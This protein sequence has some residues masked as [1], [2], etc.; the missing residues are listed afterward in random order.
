MEYGSDYF[1]PIIFKSGNTEAQA[2]G[3]AVAEWLLCHGYAAHVMESG[4]PLSELGNIFCVFVLGGDGTIIGVARQL[5]GKGI[6]IFGINFGRVG[7]LSSA[8]PGNWQDVF[9]S[10]LSHGTLE[11]LAL[12]WKLIKNSG[13]A[14]SGVAVNELVLSRGAIARLVNIRVG[15]NYQSLG[16]LRCD[17][18]IICTP[19]GSTGYSVSAGG[20][21]MSAQME[22]I[23]L[24]PICPYLTR[25]S[26]M[27]FPGSTNFS[28]KIFPGSTDCYMTVDGQEGQK[29][30]VEDVLEVTGLPG[31][32]RF[33]AG[34]KH[35][36]QKLGAMG[37]A[38]E[39]GSRVDG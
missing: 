5:V 34:K 31:S 2:F 22:A 39:R 11:C 32:V 25:L 9:L 27:V 6:P 13:K 19:I 1:I 33:M 35:F 26:P 14:I 20:S 36:L 7:F 23:G 4:A 12:S 18:L 15:I 17:G 10:S 3:K 38:F 16:L 21:V 8:E 37:F 28:L 30:E 29:L 24:T